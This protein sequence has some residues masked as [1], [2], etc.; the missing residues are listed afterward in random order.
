MVK[1]M[2]IVHETAGGMGKE[3]SRL[4]KEVVEYAK[5]QNIV[6]NLVLISDKSWAHGEPPLAERGEHTAL[7]C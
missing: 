7:R 3:A 5:S 2:M 4:F 6:C 1:L